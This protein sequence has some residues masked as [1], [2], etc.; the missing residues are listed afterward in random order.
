MRKFATFLLIIVSIALVCGGCIDQAA[1]QVVD[2]TFP[3]SKIKSIT[4]ANDS[5]DIV[6]R[7][8][9]GSDILIKATKAART[10]D[11]LNGMDVVVQQIGDNI[12]GTLELIKY[13]GRF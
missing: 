5:G 2:W 12:A 8:A 11:D 13:F 6:V 1:S 3:A 9:S 7:Q 10:I 4:L